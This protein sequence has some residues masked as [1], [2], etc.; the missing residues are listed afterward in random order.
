MRKKRVVEENNQLIERLYEFKRNGVSYIDALTE[1]HE[2]LNIEMEDLIEMV[3]NEILHEIKVE[4]VQKRMIRDDG[5]L[6]Q[7]VDI[8]KRLNNI[9]DFLEES[10]IEDNE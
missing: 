2:T 10:D 9:M 8:R 7:E 5:D 3:P 1:L 4:F 6:N